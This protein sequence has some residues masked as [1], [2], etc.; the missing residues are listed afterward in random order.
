M[1]AAQRA[2]QK[3]RE[4]QAAHYNAAQARAAE[5]GPM[6]LVGF[7]SD[8]CRKVAKDALA[9]GD[10]SVADKL[11]AHLNDFYRAHSQ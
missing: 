4:N 8:I 5:Q 6:H 7:W 2:A 10:R 11:A 9:A 3:R 1:N